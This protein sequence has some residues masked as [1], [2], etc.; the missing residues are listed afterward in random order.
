[1]NENIKVINTCYN[2]EIIFL[3][4]MKKNENMTH[5]KCKNEFYLWYN[6]FIKT[7]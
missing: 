5:D 4:C 6:C 7:Y 3:N 1:M 2:F